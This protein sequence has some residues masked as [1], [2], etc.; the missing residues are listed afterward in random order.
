MT[1][2]EITNQESKTPGGY[3]KKVADAIV[4]AGNKF[5]RMIQGYRSQSEQ[6]IALFGESGSGKTTLLTVFTDIN[7]MPSSK[8]RRDTAFLPM[9]SHRDNNCSVRFGKYHPVLFLPPDWHHASTLSKS[10]WMGFQRQKTQ[11]IWFGMI[12]PAVGGQKQEPDRSKWTRKKHFSHSCPRTLP[13]SWGMAP[14]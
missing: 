8:K 3:A 11:P 2:Q 7:R 6:H 12:I 4:S 5:G 10:A 13:C 9:M 14:S 1:D